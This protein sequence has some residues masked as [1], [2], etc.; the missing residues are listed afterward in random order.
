MINL[1]MPMAG[2]G[3]RFLEGGI[4]MPKP[5]IDLQGKP[6][7]YWSTQSV[8]KYVDIAQIVFVILEEH[9]DKFFLDEK[10]LEFYPKAKIVYLDKVLNGAV[11]TSCEGIKVIE[12]NYPIV[13]NDCDHKFYAPAFYDFCNKADS[14]IDGALLTFESNE[15]IHSYLKNDDE[16]FVCKTIEKEVISD[17][18]ICGAYYF[19]NKQVFLGVF[20]DYLNECKYKEYFMSGIYNVL[21]KQKKK[22][23]GFPIEKL[24]S[25][26]IPKDYKVAL[27]LDLEDF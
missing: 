18:A 10:I 1:I 27:S 13:F 15:P 20:N 5:L 6:F 12:N 11:L 22:V 14:S 25:F 16:G 19:R 21:I 3:L 24:V 8:V 17:M 4:D 7:F 26:G 2:S 23:K 9:K